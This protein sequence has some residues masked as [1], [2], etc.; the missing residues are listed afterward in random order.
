LQKKREDEIVY[1]EQVLMGN[2]NKILL[3]HTILSF[4]IISYVSAFL[5]FSNYV[6]VGAPSL[7]AQI[8]PNATNFPDKFARTEVSN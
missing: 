8:V 2:R 5:R 4:S 6:V 1:I 3:D 7:T